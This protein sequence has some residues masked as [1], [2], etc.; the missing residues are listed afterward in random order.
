MKKQVLRITTVYL[1]FFM[2]SLLA[3]CCEENIRQ[4]LILNGFTLHNMD[5][6]LK[7][8]IEL[9]PGEDDVNKNAYVIRAK[10]V[11]EFGEYIYSSIFHGMSNLSFVASAMSCGEHYTYF[12]NQYPVEIIITADTDFNEQYLADCS[13]NDLFVCLPSG[14]KGRGIYP[15]NT[16]SVEDVVNNMKG[17]VDNYYYYIDFYL[18]SPPKDSGLY[19]FYV[20]FIMSDES[21]FTE[22]I[23]VNLK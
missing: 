3:S 18:K 23:K 2:L 10:L 12:Y 13:L 22:Q 19:T 4:E 9:S 8:P 11:N 5:N 14:S 21:I 6:S 1:L 15:Y 16:M 17:D 7:Y 20:S